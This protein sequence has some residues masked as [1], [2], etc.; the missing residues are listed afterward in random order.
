MLGSGKIKL[1]EKLLDS[2][3]DN[4]DQFIFYNTEKKFQQQIEIQAILN[5]NN[6]YKVLVIIDQKSPIDYLCMKIA[7]QME[8]FPEYTNLEGLKA[9]NLTKKGEKG[10]LKI[11]SSGDIREHL[12]DGDIIYCDLTT[13]ECWVKTT[14]RM[15]SLYSRLT[16]NLDLKFK[17]TTFFKKLKF[18]LIKLGLNF[19][20]DYAKGQ[21]DNFHYIF[22]Q[23]KF[24]T[25][26]SKNN[27]EFNVN[28]L[29][30]QDNFESKKLLELI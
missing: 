19:W 14:I 12:N 16:I 11:P 20:V 3:Q 1:K 2:N 24:K 15:N 18:L 17:L 30:R 27:I 26:K 6:S 7:E 25:L 28:D 22:T 10:I 23:A 9:T 29:N 4:D 8:K 21:E 5:S 13:R